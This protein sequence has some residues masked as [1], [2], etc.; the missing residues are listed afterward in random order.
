MPILGCLVPAS[1]WRRLRVSLAVLFCTTAPAG[2][3]TL[4]VLQGRV[5]DASGAAL[6]GASITIQ[7][8]STPFR[9]TVSTDAEGRYYVPAIPAGSHTVTA[10]DVDARR[11][12]VVLA[13]HACGA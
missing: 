13:E 11:V 4:G 8:E 7:N 6:P 9:T 12:T 5:F 1:G 10:A 3:Q 2:A